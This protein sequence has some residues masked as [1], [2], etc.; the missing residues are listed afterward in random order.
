MA[1]HCVLAAVKPLVLA[2]H[3]PAVAGIVPRAPRVHSRGHPNPAD[4]NNDESDTTLLA[5]SCR[6]SRA[7]PLIPEPAPE[8]AICPSVPLVDSL[9]AHANDLTS[10]AVPPKV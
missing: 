6:K 4:L 9:S 1:E 7:N 2:D 5:E 8:A 3:D 10:D